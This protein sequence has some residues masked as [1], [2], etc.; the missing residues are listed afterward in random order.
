MVAVPVTYK[1]QPVRNLNGFAGIEVGSESLS[2]RFR[3][4]PLGERF[5]PDPNPPQGMEWKRYPNPYEYKILNPTLGILAFNPIGATYKERLGW[6][7][8]DLVAKIDYTVKDWHFIKEAKRVPD[9]LD[10]HLSL[11]RLMQVGDFLIDQTV[12]G[13]V[14]TGLVDPMDQM[15][16]Y[17]P[18]VLIVDMTTGEVVLNDFSGTGQ[19]PQ[20]DVLIDY[21]N[22][23][24]TMPS[25][26]LRT[27]DPITGNINVYDRAQPGQDWVGRVF[28]FYYKV[29][30][31]W[32]VAP[33]KANFYY[34]QAS[35]MT[36]PVYNQYLV[37]GPF[38]SPPDVPSPRF[39]LWFSIGNAGK[40]VAVDY[41]YR[42]AGGKIGK[43]FGEMHTISSPP[44]PV[45]GT[46]FNG[47]YL[48]LKQP[49]PSQGDQLI[50]VDKVKGTSFKIRAVWRD[51][52]RWRK[53]D[54]DTYLTRDAR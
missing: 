6:Y 18:D 27:I 3:L 53:N 9:S 10:I 4:L 13:G 1:G 23:I 36:P 14:P 21:K 19:N 46:N 33:S 50:S 12:Y 51:G 52:N 16:P 34:T 26:Y 29:D 45:P 11:P 5:S 38:A 43:V 44:Q 7:T 48:V 39:P 37:G 30:G 24:I 25:R 32:A 47:C 28:R 15:T 8:Q 41:T 2:R 20:T 40:S 42:M 17:N 22:G 31:E 35:P 54:I 49:D